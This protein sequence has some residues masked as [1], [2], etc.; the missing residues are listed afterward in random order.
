MFCF[1]Y[2]HFLAR[3]KFDKWL[4]SLGMITSLSLGTFIIFATHIAAGSR[5]GNN[6]ARIFLFG[7]ALL[8]LSFLLYSQN[9]YGGSSVLRTLDIFYGAQFIYS[10][11]LYLWGGFYG[12][13]ESVFEVNTNNILLNFESRSTSNGLIKLAAG[14]GLPGILILSYYLGRN[15]RLT[16]GT[17]TSYG[18][19]FAM[20]HIMQPITFSLIWFIMIAGALYRPNKVS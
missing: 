6:I 4:A 14:I 11:Y 15:L 7:T 12:I 13:I 17:R 2:F 1:L 5:R 20:L 8:T 3:N 19:T 10:N 18:A 9:I 16:F